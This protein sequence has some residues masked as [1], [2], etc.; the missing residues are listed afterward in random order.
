MSEHVICPKEKEIDKLYKTV[1]DGNG[2]DSLCTQITKM[3]EK[4]DVYMKRQE[5][6]IKEYGITNKEFYEFKVQVKTIYEEQQKS[7]ARKRWRTGMFITI[8]CVIFSVIFNWLVKL[9]SNEK[10]LSN[11]ID[12]SQ[13]QSIPR[14]GTL[15]DSI[16]VFQ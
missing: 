5:D 2:H 11:R 16:T 9:N 4:L 6:L 13:I 1:I 3:S 7:E 15:V 12:S 10:I 14:G 8:A